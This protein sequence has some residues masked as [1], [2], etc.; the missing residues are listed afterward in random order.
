MKRSTGT[1]STCGMVA[2]WMITLMVL[3]FAGLA[4]STYEHARALGKRCATCHDSVHPGAENLNSTGRF[5]QVN[6]R[7]PG[8]G[9][10]PPA[11][12]GQLQE[13]GAAIYKRACAT[14]HG[15]DGSGTALGPN[16][17]GT[18]KSEA[19]PEALIAIV[20]N[21]V[22]GTA[23]VAFKGTLSDEQIERSVEHLLALRKLPSP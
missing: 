16:L 19:T 11:A 13:S 20:R 8:D 3:P 9:G 12:P 14:C 15:P 23:M 21:G 7:L 4:G 2:A 6:R 18:L 10:R 17:L 22:P 5:F 1:L